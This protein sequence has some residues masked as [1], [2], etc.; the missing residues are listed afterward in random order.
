MFLE[1]Y[2][3]SVKSLTE[4]DKVLVSKRLLIEALGNT[5]RNSINDYNYLQRDCYG[6]T[7]R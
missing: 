7:S 5:A 1:S 4:I 6:G 2:Q 3:E